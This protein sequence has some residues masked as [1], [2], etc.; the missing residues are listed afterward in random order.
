MTKRAFIQP[1]LSSKR[2]AEINHSM[3]QSILH[4]QKKNP[5]RY[6]LLSPS[7]MLRLVLPAAN[8]L[9]RYFCR[10]VW[11]MQQAAQIDP[12]KLRRM[13]GCYPDSLEPARLAI[14][15]SSVSFCRQP[16]EQYQSAFQPAPKR[17]GLFPDHLQPASHEHLDYRRGFPSVA[18]HS[19]QQRSWK[20]GFTKLLP[21][22]QFKTVHVRRD[23]QQVFHSAF[24][25]TAAIFAG[26]LTPAI[27]FLNQCAKLGLDRSSVLCRDFSDRLFRFITDFSNRKTAHIHSPIDCNAVNVINDCTFINA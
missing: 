23:T 8:L 6:A 2:A 24:S 17:K 11:Q 19:S 14:H 21:L 18:K 3:D 5:S 26:G 25:R 22:W 15:Q 7:H 12:R 27:S 1:S 20:P 10:S 4:Q 16:S 9:L 13:V